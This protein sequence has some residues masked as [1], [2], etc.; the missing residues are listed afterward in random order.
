VASSGDSRRWALW[1][2]L[3]IALVGGCGVNNPTYFTPPMG[4]I[5]T[6]QGD[7]GAQ[8]A[9]VVVVPF[10]EPNN[11]ENA[12]IDEASTALGFREPWLRRDQVAVSIQYSI[13]NLD[14]Q[15]GKAQVMVDG[16]NEFTTYDSAAIAAAAQAAAMNEDDVIVLP[17][18]QTIPV[19][20]QPG[21][22]YSGVI[23]EDDFAEAELD[24][25]AIGRWMAP[26][27]AVLINASEVNPI[28]L[29]K[30][31][32]NEVVPAMF[33]LAVTLS[34]EPHMRLDF[35]VRVRDSKNRLLKLDEA[36]SAF[37]PQPM[38]YTPPVMM[39]P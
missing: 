21:D 33:R 10:R 13:T 5:E 11:N 30:V 25:D 36:G 6:G 29:D 31:P 18:L 28:G 2:P 37:A 38:G 32:A 7:A 26:P 17:L 23:R 15:A 34:A 9:T 39:A 20:I 1:L 24:L 4:A 16:S 12:R 35:L 19:V 27:A 14:K 3:I 22:T 8:A